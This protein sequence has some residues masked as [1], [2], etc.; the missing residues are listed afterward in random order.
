MTDTDYADNLKRKHIIPSGITTAEPNIKISS[1]RHWSLYECNLNSICVINKSEPFPHQ[2][3]SLKK[4]VD[5]FSYLASNI[6]STKSDVNI[7]LE[8]MRNAV[9]NLSMILKFDRS[10]K[11][12]RISS[13][14]QM[15]LSYCIDAPHGQ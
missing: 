13:K 2:V 15:N 8:N 7:C 11:I 5:Q 14:L 4:L 9:D 1:S 12:K 10:D 6:S 3:A